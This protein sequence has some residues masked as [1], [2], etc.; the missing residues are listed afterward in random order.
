[1]KLPGGTKEESGRRGTP[2]LYGGASLG[3]PEAGD[4]GAVMDS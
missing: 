3:D 1:L 4:G 2:R